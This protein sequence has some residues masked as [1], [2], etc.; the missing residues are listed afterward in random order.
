MSQNAQHSISAV[1]KRSFDIKILFLS[2]SLSVPP[3]LHGAAIVLPSTEIDPVQL[4]VASA[5]LQTLMFLNHLLSFKLFHDSG[6]E[7]EPLHVFLVCFRLY[8]SDFGNSCCLVFP[9]S[10]SVTCLNSHSLTKS[11]RTLGT[12]T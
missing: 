2:L 4:Y 1:L 9:Q 7:I 12:M 8:Y 6:S 10:S 5:M 3:S 11:L